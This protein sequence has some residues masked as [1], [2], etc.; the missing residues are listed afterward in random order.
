MPNQLQMS[1]KNSICIISFLFIFNIGFTQITEKGDKELTFEVNGQNLRMTYFGNKDISV[2]DNTVKLAVI[3]IHGIDRNGRDYF[4]VIAQ[5]ADYANLYENNV[6]LTPQYIIPTD[7]TT[8]NLSDDYLYWDTDY[9]RGVNS[10]NTPENITSFGV[11]DSMVNQLVNSYPNL[12][13]I[14]ISGHSRGGQLT[15]R[16]AGSNM[17]ENNISV[18]I[19]YVPAGPSSYFYL[20]NER[21]IAGTEDQFAVPTTTCTE[22]NDWKYGLDDLS[23]YPYVSAVGAMTIRN[24]YKDREVF[25]LVG[26]DDDDPADANLA[27]DCASMLQG[28]QRVERFNIFQNYLEQY[29]TDNYGFNININDSW[30]TVSG[31]GHSNRS[32]FTSTT[33]LNAEFNLN[34]DDAKIKLGWQVKNS[35]LTNKLLRDVQFIDADHGWMVGDNGTIYRTI[36]GG[37]TWITPSYIPTTSDIRGVYFINDMTGW[38]VRSSGKVLKTI[39]GGDNWNMSSTVTNST[40]YSTF[41]NDANTGWAV[42][43]SGTIIKTTNGGTSWTIQQTTSNITDRFWRVYF[44]NDQIGW[45]VGQDGAAVRTTDGGANWVDMPVNTS[46]DLRGVHFNDANTGWI[47]GHD[48]TVLYTSNG[49]VTWDAQDATTTVNLRDIAMVGDEGFAVGSSGRIIH[50]Y[51][52][53]KTWIRQDNSLA[54]DDLWSVAMIDGDSIWAVGENGLIQQTLRG[55]Q[56]CLL[57]TSFGL[58]DTVEVEGSETFHLIADENCYSSYNFSWNTGSTSSK[59]TVLASNLPAGYTTYEVVVNDGKNCL[60]TARV[61]FLK[62]ILPVELIS[63][64]VEAI[65][66]ETVQLQWQT[67]S[68]LNN[69]YFIIERSQDAFEW[70]SLGHISGAGNS[71]EIQRYDFVDTNPHLGINYYR[72]K[73]VD[74]D[75]TINFSDIQSAVITKDYTITAFPNPTINQLFVS[76]NS[77]NV[78]QDFSTLSIELYNTLGQKVLKTNYSNISNGLIKLNVSHLEKGTYYLRIRSDEGIIENKLVSIV[79]EQ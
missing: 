67:A 63:F 14:I 8:L 36:D 20:N 13:Q 17:V 45:A 42:G 77:K 21:R 66:N 50:T 3:H 69:D 57:N 58:A 75:G 79:N 31:V 28:D 78:T 34:I 7:K 70:E 56:R 76:I 30:A 46:E 55:G 54:T 24:Q 41:F 11:L 26:R 6:F 74:L 48:G 62:A 43:N 59:I 10:L 72:L 29:Y 35:G 19:R 25:Y 49:G 64:N 37:D 73:Q 61:V 60:D 44:I 23:D 65:D 4:N 5:A 52:S 53:G 15:Q 18:P 16:Y 47:V 9:D 40:L 22:Y 71:N 12:C 33:G 1:F 27:T 38:A 68:E 2:I 51:D 32:I 39:D